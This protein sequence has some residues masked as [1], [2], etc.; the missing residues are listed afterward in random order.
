MLSNKEWK[1]LSS[2]L[3]GAVAIT[4]SGCAAEEEAVEE[5]LGV[6]DLSQLPSVTAA[7]SSGDSAVYG[8][9]SSKATTGT[10]LTDFAS[11]AFSTDSTKSG[12]MCR[13]GEMTSRLIGDAV[14][15]DRV[16]CYI[17][18]MQKN[19]LFDDLGDEDN[20]V[21]YKV[22]TPDN[23][24]E[25]LRVKFKVKKTADKSFKGFEMYTCMGATQNEYIKYEFDKKGNLDVLAVRNFSNS[26]GGATMTGGGRITVAGKTNDDGT[27]KSKELTSY[28]KFG[29]SMSGNTNSH[30][31]KIVLNQGAETSSMQGYMSS[32]GTWSSH[33]FSHTAAIGAVFELIIPEDVGDMAMGDGTAKAL[34]TG[35]Q[36]AMSTPDSKSW[37]GD[38]AGKLATASSGDF[39][40]DAQEL[41]LFDETSIADL[42]TQIAF[43]EYETWDCDVTDAVAEV[44]MAAAYQ[45]DEDFAADFDQCDNI[46]DPMQ[47]TNGMM[48]ESRT[49]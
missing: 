2:A 22:L 38:D 46:R 9:S 7:V 8:R 10:K 40:S 27:W 24:S 29:F 49:Q 4:L 1:K 13:V 6:E 12:P 44:D 11:V 16:K 43:T 32:S 41:D 30:K 14:S 18:A 37:T 39:Y 20:F 19:G 34:F 17:G 47:G 36:M 33:S 42:D 23:G 15:P 21:K 48:C 35:G 5:A 31:Q 25:G 26:S 45:A 28:N 3:M